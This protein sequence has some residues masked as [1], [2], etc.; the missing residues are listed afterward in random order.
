[1]WIVNA[2][3]CNHNSRELKK[4]KGQGEKK[5]WDRAEENGFSQEGIKCFSSCHPVTI[6]SYL[7]KEER[8]TAFHF[9]A[10]T[11]AQF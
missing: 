9:A 6:A 11:I 7:Q 4:E 3:D 1:M 8:R 2:H 10:R 5:W